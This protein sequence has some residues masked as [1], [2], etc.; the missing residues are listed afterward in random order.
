MAV[1]TSR[2]WL[3][4]TLAGQTYGFDVHSVREI[5]SLRDMRIHRLPES[6]PL[7]EGVV[8][9]RNRPIEV[10]DVRAALGM[11]PLHEETEAISKLLKEREED[12]CR[13]IQELEACVAENRE[14]KLATNPHKCKFGQWYDK[15]LGDVIELAR[16]TN[17]DLALVTTLEQLDEPHRKI[18]G[19]AER[20]LGHVAAGEVAEARRVIDETR[21][22]ELRALRVIFS[23]CRE[24]IENSRRGLL[25]VFTTEGGTVGGL[26]DRVSEVARFSDDQIHPASDVDVGK[27]LLL[28][29]AE[30]GDAGKMIQ[31]LDV[32]AIARLRLGECKAPPTPA[33]IPIEAVVN[34]CKGY[35]PAANSIVA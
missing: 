7:V 24:Q 6:S 35:V 4:F 13:W 1:A 3:I 34:A 20:V 23:K 33:P 2:Q 28:G 8:S 10:I 25:F 29:L 19:I 17:N 16:L 30:Y 12:H 9:L 21:E 32:E 5:V 18:H 22:T 27:E 31:L 14:F 26:V 11:P 15:L